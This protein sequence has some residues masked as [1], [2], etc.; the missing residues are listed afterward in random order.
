MWPIGCKVLF[1]GG[2]DVGQEKA[3]IVFVQTYNDNSL[4]HKI[5]QA[6]TILS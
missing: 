3:N 1:T 6:V 4:H 5:I 2:Y